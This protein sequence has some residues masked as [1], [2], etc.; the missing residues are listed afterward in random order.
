MCGVTE[1]FNLGVGV[2]QGLVLSPY[3]F[4]VV[5]GEVTKEYIEYDFAGRDQEVD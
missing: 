4:S 3:L 2:N 5:M 1:D